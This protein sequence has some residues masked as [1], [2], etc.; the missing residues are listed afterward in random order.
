MMRRILAMMVC[1]GAMSAAA[2]GEVQ[3]GQFRGPTGQGHASAKDVPVK[4]SETE[5]VVWKTP[6][7]G[8]GWSSPVIADGVVWV[9]TG[10]DTPAT[11]QEAE[12]RLEG[13]T[14]S[15]PL[16]VSSSATLR[17]VGVDL[18]SGKV[19]HD[20]ELMTVRDPQWIHQLNS[21]ASPTPVVEADRLYC[22]F[23]ALGT[24]AVDTKSGKVVWRNTDSDLVVAHENGPGSS[25]IVH[26]DLLIF[27]CDGSDRQFIAA[28][29]KRTGK[30][31]WKTNRSGEM[32][33]HPQL[34][35]SYGTPLVVEVNGKAQLLSPASDWLYAYD[36]ATGRE[37][38]KVAYEALGFSVVP[39]PVVGHGM[40]YLSTSFMQ[41]QLLA[42]QY[43]GVDQPSIVWR[44]NRGV[45]QVPSPLLVGDELYFVSDQGGVVT[46]L[47]AKTGQE[48]W[49]ERLDGKHCASPLYADGRIY[50][51]SREGETAVLEPGTTF[52][53]IAT[54]KLDGQIMATPAAID[55]AL[56]VRTDQALY[57][58]GR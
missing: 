50:L 6:I 46:C 30:L 9:T 16:V 22:H 57:R 38:W 17:A 47:D 15:Q 40:A 34:K 26:G 35:K 51:F 36:P 2:R 24:A 45:P 53:L 21:Y 54:N 4:W 10:F 20:I 41:S 28:L 52:K 31:A 18:T 39:R 13:N 14:N 1:V 56:I 49:R 27:H 32:N 7:A 5:A 44:Y 12:K 42:V 3:W 23:G 37:L 29:D 43:K 55:G 8:R 11:P 33:A 58:I 19:I 48:R 25:P